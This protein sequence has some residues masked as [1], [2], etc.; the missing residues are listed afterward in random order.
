MYIIIGTVYWIKY[1]AIR[2]LESW[3]ERIAQVAKDPQDHQVQPQ[4][5]RT[6]LTNNPPLNHVPEHHTETVF[7]HIQGWWLNHLPGEP[8]PVF[9]NPFCKEGFPDV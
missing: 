6:T 2:Y 4:P 9:N 3:N 1:A 7:K 5:N 8:V